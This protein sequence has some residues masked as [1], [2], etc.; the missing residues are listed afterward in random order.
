MRITNFIHRAIR[1]LKETVGNPQPDAGMW[2][3]LNEWEFLSPITMTLNAACGECSL[4]YSPPPRHQQEHL[5]RRHSLIYKQ[6]NLLSPFSPWP[7]LQIPCPGNS[8]ISTPTPRPP[9]CIGVSPRVFVRSR[10]PGW[11]SSYL[12]S[13]LRPVPAL[14]WS[15]PSLSGVERKE[16]ETSTDRSQKTP[17]SRH[18]AS[19]WRWTGRRVGVD[20]V[21]CLGPM[22]QAR[23]RG[24]GKGTD[25][26]EAL[27]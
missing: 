20:N 9:S 12:I 3:G 14:T 5:Q 11:S 26:Q 19:T 10:H 8:N 21:Q 1:G 22:P 16:R 7:R 25:P 15:L 18:A 6:S 23:G 24:P 4:D 13:L 27:R 17:S 2:E